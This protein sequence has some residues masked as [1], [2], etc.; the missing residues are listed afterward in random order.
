LGEFDYLLCN[1]PGGSVVYRLYTQGQGLRETGFVEGQNVSIE[2]RSAEGDYERLPALA[3]ELV[4][5]R[6]DLLAA[7]GTPAV[8]AAKIASR[9][10]VPVIPVVFSTGSD[11]VAEGFVES[12][13]RPGGNMTGVTSISGALASKRFETVREFLRDDAAIAILINP[14]N[15]LSEMEQREAEAASRAIGQ[16]LEILAA[17]DQAEIDRAF[18]AL[19]QRRNISVLIIAVDMVYTRRCSELPP[20]PRR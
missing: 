10:S 20:S 1:E 14:N 17:R 13:S 15:P 9:T 4:G 11:P 18:A 5:L 2:S 7:F 3:A 16:R 19:K 6:V 12:L 8:Q